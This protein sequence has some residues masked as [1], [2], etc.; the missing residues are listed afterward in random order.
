[1]QTLSW[2]HFN[3]ELFLNFANPEK[4]TL[5]IFKY[6]SNTN[7]KI[8][9]WVY[10]VLERQARSALLADPIISTILSQ[11]TVNITY[12]PMEC[13]EAAITREEMDHKHHHGELVEDDVARCGEQS[14]STVGF[15]SI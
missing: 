14:G 2:Q 15:G 3:F 11:L 6:T 8:V 9:I 1:M 4:A 5:L 12:E 13:P 10:D 7:Q